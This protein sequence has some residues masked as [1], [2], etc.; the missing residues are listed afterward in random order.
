[1][2]RKWV[3]VLA[4]V[5]CLA[6]VP[7]AFAGYQD[8]DLVNKTGEDIYYV[9]VS[10]SNDDYWGEDVMDED[11]LENGYMVHIRFSGNSDQDMWDIKVEDGEGN[12]TIWEGF[13]LSRV[14]KVTLFPKG[15]AEYE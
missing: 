7:E 5:F 11:V 12:E 14:S 3:S 10:A 15:R 6:L 4:A 8:F 13:D 9:Y 1:M 2:I